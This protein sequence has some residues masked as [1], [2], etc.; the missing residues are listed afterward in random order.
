MLPFST[1]L[2]EEPTSVGEKLTALVNDTVIYSDIAGQTL[3]KHP[4]ADVRKVA[5]NSTH[6]QNTV[7]IAPSFKGTY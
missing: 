1:N 4:V 5:L 6:N 7:T 3:T 2:Q